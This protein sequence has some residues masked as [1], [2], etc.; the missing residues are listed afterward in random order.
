MKILR[1][2]VEHKL[3]G[4]ADKKWLALFQACCLNFD[5]IICEL[6]GERLTLSH[7][8]SFALQFSKINF[9]QAS[10]INRYEIP[11]HIEST[12]AR[13]SKDM[14]EEQAADI[15]YQFRVVY[16]LD[17]VTKARSHFQFVQPASAEGKEIR[18][19]LV[20]HKL[21][22]HLYPHKPSDVIDAVVRESGKNFNQHNHTQAWRKFKVRPKKGADQ[23]ENTNRDF[24]I[25]HAAHDDYTFSDQWVQY[26]VSQVNDEKKFQEL[27][28]FKLR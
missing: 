15:E 8:L 16:T 28:S 10:T 20:Q 11:A 7:E 2:D 5:K 19:V 27:T 22:D 12:D 6:F 17:A 18:N 1:D 3:L 25:Y 26:L 4:R 24:C 9:D 13:L 14:T 23:P 21:A